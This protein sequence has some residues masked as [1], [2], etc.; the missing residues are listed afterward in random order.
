M[1]CVY[2]YV[3]I[4]IFTY[5]YTHICIRWPITTEGNKEE[6]VTFLFIYIRHSFKKSAGLYMGQLYNG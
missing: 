5:I 2:I 1:V 3:H 4:Y 6:K